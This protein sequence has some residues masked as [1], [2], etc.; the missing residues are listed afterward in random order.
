MDG[1]VVMRDFSISD[2]LYR[3]SLEQISVNRLRI[4]NFVWYRWKRIE[5]KKAM[6]MTLKIRRITIN[7]ISTIGLLFPVTNIIPASKKAREAII[8]LYSNA[9]KNFSS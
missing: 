7:P 2:I 1:K 4:G 9:L 5:R 8:S 3:L 6:N